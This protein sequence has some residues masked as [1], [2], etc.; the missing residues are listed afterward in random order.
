MAVWRAGNFSSMFHF[1]GQTP[2]QLL[3]SWFGTFLSYLSTHY[4]TA[5]VN[6]HTCR[7]IV[8]VPKSFCITIAVT[9]AY[10]TASLTLWIMARVSFQPTWQFSSLTQRRWSI[11]QSLQSDFCL[12]TVW[13]SIQLCSRWIDQL[14]TWPL[15][16][17]EDS[18]CQGL[19]SWNYKGTS[20]IVCSVVEFAK[21][22]LPKHFKHS[23]FSSFV[24][25]LNM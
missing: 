25:Q 14:L 2:M 21:D 15:S 20:F 6:W 16:M 4:G 12:Q 19:I 23:N 11:F 1:I 3:L 9:I 5:T 17:I 13:V 7:P 8:Y 22:V 18:S 24:R 10:I